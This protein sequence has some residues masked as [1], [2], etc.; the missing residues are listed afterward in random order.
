MRHSVFAGKRVRLKSRGRAQR[1]TVLYGA[2][3][4][5][6]DPFSSVPGGSVD[7]ARHESGPS[8]TF[9]PIPPTIPAFYEKPQALYLRFCF[10]A[11]RRG[12]GWPPKRSKWAHFVADG[13]RD[14]LREAKMICFPPSPGIR[15]CY[16]YGAI[17]KLCRIT[18][19][20]SGLSSIPAI[21]EKP[22]AVYLH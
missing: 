4:E 22:Q 15:C 2:L 13:S 16:Q 21:F 20:K 11:F 19:M 10:L 12:W 6:N 7:G 5:Q 8:T 1:L 3:Q 18:G 14:G 9:S 17:S